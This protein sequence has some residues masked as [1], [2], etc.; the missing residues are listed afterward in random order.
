M[1]GFKID[2]YVSVGVGPSHQD[3]RTRTG[4]DGVER[5]II[6]LEIE[7]EDLPKDQIPKV[8]AP[9]KKKA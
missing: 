2:G 1:F 6:K 5:K 8:Y 9:P 4:K 3:F 7:S